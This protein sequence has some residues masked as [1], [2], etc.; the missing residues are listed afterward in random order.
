MPKGLVRYSLQPACAWSLRFKCRFSSNPVTAN[1]KI[2]SRVYGMPA[3]QWNACLLAGVAAA[4][5][6]FG[7]D[8]GAQLVDGPTED[9]NCHQGRTA[10]GVYVADGIGGGDLPEF[11][12]IIHNGHEKIRGADNGSAVAQIVHRRIVFAFVAHQQAGIGSRGQ[13]RQRLG[14]KDVFQ[15][16]GRDFTATAGAMAVF[17]HT[18]GRVALI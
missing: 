7:G 1:P 6:D 15:Q 8:V 3:R 2:G 13:S 11:K 14:F 18:H 9:S 12:G 4:V 10:H 5:Y 16:L 17:R